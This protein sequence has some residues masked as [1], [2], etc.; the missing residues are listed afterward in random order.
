MSLSARSTSSSTRCN[1]ATRLRSARPRVRAAKSSCSA[2]ATIST[3]TFSCRRSASSPQLS[4][5]ASSCSGSWMRS[6]TGWKKKA[7][8]RRPGETFDR[9]L[10]ARALLGDPGAHLGVEHRQRQWSHSE[11]LVVEGADVEPVAQRLFR[12]FAQGLDPELADLVGQCLARPGNVTI[13]LVVDVEVALAGV[14][15]EEVDRLV[16]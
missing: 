9:R 11:K 14:L 7:S 3:R 6:K 8:P 5:V 12:L 15:F 2:A 13:D 4:G 1:A 16:A 10:S